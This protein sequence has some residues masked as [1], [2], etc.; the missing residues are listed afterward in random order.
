MK[1]NQV[2]GLL[3]GLLSITAACGPRATPT[4]PTGGTV[5]PTVKLSELQRRQHAA[6]AALGPK[7]TECA[8]A[9]A[10]ASMSAAELAKLD[11]QRTGP[12]HTEVFIDD[13]SA[14]SYSSRQVR[15]LEV[16]FHEETECEALSA[17]LA[18]IAPA[19]STPAP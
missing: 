4:T 12:K 19:K 18:N 16:C 1:S 9:D 6:C 3:V 14:E 13:C 10:K 17:C 2:A 8:V 15:V 11:L 5:E 7:L